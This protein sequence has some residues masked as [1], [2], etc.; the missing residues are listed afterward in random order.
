MFGLATFAEGVG[1]F[2][3]REKRDGPFPRVPRGDL[4]VWNRW[5][6]ARTSRK[7]ARFCVGRLRRR[8]LLVFLTS[9]LDDPVL[10]ES[11]TC[12][13]EPLSRQHV[14]RVNA[15]RPAGVAPLFSDPD[16]GARVRGVEDVYRRLGGH[17]RWQRLRERE[18][19]LKR[20]GVRFSLLDPARLTAEI[21]TQYL[22]V[23]GRQIL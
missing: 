5:E 6:S 19:L 22:D 11:F 15:L 8:A 17:L 4:R 21:I 10:A 13:V 7:S 12:A 23:K 3:A 2:R 14:I 16:E 18:H 20:L 1:T 9:S